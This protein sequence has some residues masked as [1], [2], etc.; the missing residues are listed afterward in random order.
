MG[1]A[2]DLRLNRIEFS[3]YAGNLLCRQF[4]P[5]AMARVP[6]CENYNIERLLEIVMGL[7]LFWRPARRSVLPGFGLITAR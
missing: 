4:I 7:A 3:R 2:I 1:K 5:E 6:D